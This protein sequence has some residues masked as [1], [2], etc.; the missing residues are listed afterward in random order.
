MHPA[1]TRR[2]ARPIFLYSAIS[3]MVSMDSCLAGSMKLHVF[4]TSTSAWSGCGVSSCPRATSSPIMTSLSTRFLGQPKLTNPTFNDLFSAEEF[5]L[6]RIAVSGRSDC[7]LLRKL[8]IG[9]NERIDYSDSRFSKRLSTARVIFCFTWDL[10]ISIQG[11]L[12]GPLYASRR[13]F[14]SRCDAYNGPINLPCILM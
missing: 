10:V 8:A 11:R 2:W 12:I 4:T 1:T 7:P 9:R 5:L 3:R 6:Y 13:E 14:C